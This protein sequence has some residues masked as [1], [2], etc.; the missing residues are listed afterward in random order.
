[1]SAT[2]TRFNDHFAPV[3]D[4]YAAHRPT[5]PAELFAWL[6][7]WC[8]NRDLAWDCATG[9]GQ[10]AVAL[11]RHF[12]EV[13]AT[14]ASAAQIAAATP[15][16][17][18]SYRVAPADA[19]GLAAQSADL[20]TV[21]QALHWFDLEQFYAEVRRVL[22]PGGL[23][24]VWTYGVFQVPA[25]GSADIQALLDRFYHETVGPYWPPERRHVENGYADL[26]FPFA[27]LVVPSFVMAVDWQLA[28]LAGYLRSWSATSRYREI[29]G[30]DPVSPLLHELVPVWGSGCQRVV[31]PLSIR[32]GRPLAPL[33]GR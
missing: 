20:V 18:V 27:E 11:A 5:Y 23:L 15:A 24:A 4:Q 31:W 13:V 7:G 21:A 29:N 6:A 17:G 9:T 30:T 14:D 28:D 16:A 10:A 33:V 8:A 3:A 12:S 19:S 25:A 2:G 1:M 32:V 26:A 22:K